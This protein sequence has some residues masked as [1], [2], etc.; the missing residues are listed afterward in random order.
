MAQ[1]IHDSY[2]GQFLRFASGGKLL[3]YPE[4]TNP[5][6]LKPY[7]V[8]GGSARDDASD[9]SANAD[10]AEKGRDVHLVDWYGPQDPEVSWSSLPTMTALTHLRIPRTG[11][12][13]QNPLSRLSYVS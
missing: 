6:L 3:P 7:T 9:S 11:P 12:V 4:Q 5:S 2:F 10:K 8:N 1:L 13:S